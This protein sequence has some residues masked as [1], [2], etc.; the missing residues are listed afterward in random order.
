[1]FKNEEILSV[2]NKV[3]LNKAPVSDNVSYIDWNEEYGML[4]EIL[5]AF[6]KI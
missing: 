6:L 2:L 3:N 5:D 4:V 1:M